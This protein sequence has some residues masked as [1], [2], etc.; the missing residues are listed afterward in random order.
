MEKKK[1]DW[2]IL[3]W[4]AFFLSLWLSHVFNFSALKDNV[5]DQH[6]KVYS[7]QPV[8]FHFTLL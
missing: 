1:G 4:K 7:L 6:A 8:V 2:V 5:V 3:F